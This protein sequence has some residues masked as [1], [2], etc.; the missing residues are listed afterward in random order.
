MKSKTSFFNR[1]IAKNLLHR[2]WP[3]WA[4]Y[5]VFL[6]LIL[7]LMLRQQTQ[8]IRGYIGSIPMLDS[9]AAGMG[10]EMQRNA[11]EQMK[12]INQASEEIKRRRPSMK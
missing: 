9:F 11:A 1:G 6:L 2:C 12:E 4:G 5:Q 10:E 3:L 7:P 8:S